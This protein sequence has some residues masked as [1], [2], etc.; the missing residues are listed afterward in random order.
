MS[1]VG[2]V[3]LVG[4]GPG[5][6][7][8]ITVKGTEALRAADVV[9]YDRLI[10]PRLLSYAPPRA[11]RIYVGKQSARHTLRQEEINALLVERAQAGQTVVRLKG[12]D[13]FVFGRGG[14]EA[15]TLREAGIPF[16]VV[17]GV[18]SAIAAATY[19]G[20]PVTHRGVTSSLAV[21]TGHEDPTKE[22]SSLH[23]EGLAT[24]AGTLV[25][26][27][28]VENLPTLVGE[29]LRHGRSPQTPVALVRWGT[30]PQQETV[31]GT[32]G[33]IVDT[34]AAREQPFGAPAVIVVGEVVAL[35]ERL[36]WFDNRPLW[37]KRVLITR[38]RDQAGRLAHLLAEQGA[39]PI[40]VPA[41]AIAP[42]D[43]PGPLDDALGRIREYTW[44]VFTSVNGVAGVFARLEAQGRD[45]RALA[46]VRVCAIG[47]ATAASLRERGIRPDFVPDAFLTREVAKGLA[48]LGVAGKRVL[49]PRTDIVGED[50]AGA[51]YEA[52]AAVD[53]V[54]AY[55][56][57]PA[58]E[59]DP[60]VREQLRAGAIDLV[61][62]TSSSTVRNLVS[63]LGD[64]RAVLERCTIA[65][66]GPITTRTAHEL[67]LRVEIEAQEHTV[68]GLMRAILEHVAR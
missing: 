52:G 45:A 42:P 35:R 10:D 63:L 16:E 44:V 25:F 2:K 34:L 33:D 3:Y 31:T 1:N 11:E 49:L 58:Q 62:F 39:D 66:I 22:A 46:G 7:G 64:D 26:L 60:E 15:E 17:P 38:S 40:E 6:P 13:P 32:L 5:D 14:E 29:L 23:L 43:D 47:P 61:T 50:L 65:S 67:G 12:G 27:M 56:T 24:A 19:A 8:L 37:G 28:G 48:D 36:R 55:R 4:G 41:I 68:P 57:L 53:Q 21:I 51:L 30:W 9:V 20:I 18:T 59:I 54:V